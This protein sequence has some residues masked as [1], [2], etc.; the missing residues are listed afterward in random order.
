[1]QTNS[2]LFCFQFV[3][4]RSTVRVFLL[5]LLLLG[6]LRVLQRRQVRQRAPP[7]PLWSRPVRRG[8]ARKLQRGETR[9]EKEWSRRFVHGGS[10]RNARSGKI[11]PRLNRLG[12]DLFIHRFIPEK[13]SSIDLCDTSGVRKTERLQWILALSFI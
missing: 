2:K 4:G 10:N 1:M 6:H 13:K 3:S 8:T 7:L 11:W 5:A 12:S 9:L